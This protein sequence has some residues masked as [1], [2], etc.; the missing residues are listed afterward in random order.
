MSAPTKRSTMQRSLRARDDGLRKVS[1][2]TRVVVV[3]A[4]AASGLFSTLAAWAQPGRSKVVGSSA[5]AS[6]Q[7][8]ATAAGSVASSNNGG[9]GDLGGGD[10][11]N[12]SPPTTLPASSYQYAPVVVSG[13][14]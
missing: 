1:I 7:G 12:L 6:G 5:S 13:A 3:G 10:A 14:S 8:Q 11:S 4:V 9:G 2:V